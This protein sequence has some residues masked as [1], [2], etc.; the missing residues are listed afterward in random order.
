MLLMD[1]GTWNVIL[2]FIGIIALFN[3]KSIAK[4]IIGVSTP[5]VKSQ[6]EEWK[7]NNDK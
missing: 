1:L 7:K 6:Y 2:V 5:V 3:I 4:K